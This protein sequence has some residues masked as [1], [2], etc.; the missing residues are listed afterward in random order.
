MLDL[1][2]K[3]LSLKVVDDQRGCPTWARNLAL[4]SLAVIESWQQPLTAGGNGVFHYCDDQT[5]SWYEFARAI[6]RL[7]VSAGLLE[8]GPGLTPVPSSE[9][10][11]PAERPKWS[12]L[13]TRSFEQVFK[14][15][16]VSFKQSLRAVIGEIEARK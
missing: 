3:G 4:A 8:K 6:F 9:F 12:V 15:H 16:P 13:D 7:A 10:P 1:A 14:L 11:Q 5:L 2:R